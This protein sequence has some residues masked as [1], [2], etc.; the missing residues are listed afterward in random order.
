[1]SDP[2]APILEAE[3][4]AYVDGELPADRRAAVETW[5][6]AHPQDAA[7]VAAWQAQADLIKARYGGIAQEP[8]PPRLDVD[9]L[10]R[11]DRRGPLL[12][13]AAVLVAF[14]LGGLAGWF[15]RDTWAGGL[16]GM[17]VFTADAIDAHKLYVV[18]VRHPVEVAGSEQAH[19]VQW[20][21]KRLGYDVRA[22]DLSAAGL[23]LIGGRL[24][25]GAS[26]AGAALLMYEGA[27]GERFTIYCARAQSPESAL[28][29]QVAGSVAAFYWVDDNKGFVV[30]GPAD[31]DR[32]LRVAQS[33]YDQENTP[34]EKKGG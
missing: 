27:S 9:R 25:P 11:I 21:S 16:G 28:R 31:R 20:L 24:L 15:G 32:L 23:K 18:E 14:V 3:L 7:R 12:A 2:D 34:G 29:Y 5:L 19:L 22:P 33:V 30:S 1:M 17:R 13:I 8:V 10:A 6:A 26:G 4:H